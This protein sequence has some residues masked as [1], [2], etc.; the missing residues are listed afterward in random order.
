[1]CTAFAQYKWERIYGGDGRDQ[2][3]SITI[4]PDGGFIAAGLTASYPAKCYEMYLVKTDMYGDSVWTNNIGTPFN[5]YCWSIAP[6]HD[7]GFVLLGATDSIFQT[8]PHDVYLV[9]ISEQG[10]S[11]WSRVYGDT[12]SGQYTNDVGH[13]IEPTNDDGYIMIGSTESYGAGLHDIYV[14][15]TDAAGDTQWTRTFGTSMYE[16]G[17]A[18]LQTHD[19]GYIIAGT[20]YE[21]GLSQQIWILRLDATGDTMWTGLYGGAGSENVTD[22][23]QT[24]D[25]GFIFVGSTTSYGAG[26]DDLYLV[27]LDSLGA[28]DWSKTYGYQYP[29]WGNG[30]ALTSDNG[31]IVIGASRTSPDP[32]D[33]YAWLLKTDSHGDTAWTRYK[34]ET[35]FGSANGMDVQQ[36]EDGGFIIAAITWEPGGDDDFLLIKTDPDGLSVVEHSHSD[37]RTN[38]AMIPRAIPNPFVEYTV[39]PGHGQKF[40]AVYNSTGQFVGSYPGNRLGGDLPG[41]VYFAAPRKGDHEP[42]QI[43]K[44]R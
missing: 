27:K 30:I 42:I 20:T 22:I 15:K 35:V 8:G 6:A 10:D 37:N 43:I 13:R 39:I 7:S 2:A 36:A 18:G 19:N 5:D 28:I 24:P 16:T 4:A 32:E 3:F 11:L 41:G 40:F 17:Q 31:Y 29:D 33:C 14:I 26:A 34:P 12:G 1:M 21:T 44:V 38:A 9:K 25:H 23:V